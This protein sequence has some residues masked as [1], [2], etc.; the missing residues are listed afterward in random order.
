MAKAADDSKA[1]VESHIWFLD[2]QSIHRSTKRIGLETHMS[3]SRS[4]ILH[5]KLVLNHLK[6]MSIQRKYTINITISVNN[7]LV[8][9]SWMEIRGL[10]QPVEGGGR[11]EVG[12][13]EG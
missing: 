9:T 5:V 4:P 8:L 6:D 7:P 12:V 2:T 13:G 1:A 11:W 10:L 3:L